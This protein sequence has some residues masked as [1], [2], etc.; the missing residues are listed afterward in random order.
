MKREAT[1]EEYQ[2]LNAGANSDQMGNEYHAF[3]GR[4]TDLWF[5]GYERAETDRIVPLHR[6]NNASALRF[7][8]INNKEEIEFQCWCMDAASRSAHFAQ[9]QTLYDTA[10]G[11][12]VTSLEPKIG[13]KADGSSPREPQPAEKGAESTVTTVK[14]TKKKKRK[15]T[16]R[17][18]DMFDPLAGLLY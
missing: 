3:L 6:P 14:V 16:K 11:N 15:K 10:E 7:V 4:I 18:S 17:R 9:F 1:S 5:A 8:L 2:A 13:H 12:T